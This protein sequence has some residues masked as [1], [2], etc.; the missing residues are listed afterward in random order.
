MLSLHSLETDRETYPREA[1]SGF[2]KFLLATDPNNVGTGC[3]LRYSDGSSTVDVTFVDDNGDDDE[4]GSDGDDGGEIVSERRPRSR[5]QNRP[6]PRSP[7]S[8]L[9]R[10][11]SSSSQVDTQ[12]EEDI[13]NLLSEMKGMSRGVDELLSKMSTSAAGRHRKVSHRRRMS[14]SLPDLS[15]LKKAQN[16]ASKRSAGSGLGVH[17][18]RDSMRSPARSFSRRGSYS[19]ARSGA[20]SPAGSSGSKGGGERGRSSSG[21]LKRASAASFKHRRTAGSMSRSTRKQPSDDLTNSL[22]GCSTLAGAVSVHGK[23]AKENQDSYL[24][25]EGYPSPNAVVFAIFDGHGPQGKKVSQFCA[26][27]FIATLQKF[28]FHEKRK[29]GNAEASHTSMGTGTNRKKTARC[30]TVSSAFHSLHDQLHACAFDTVQSGC[31]AVACVAIPA[32]QTLVVMHCGDSSALLGSVRPSSALQH[33]SENVQG[34]FH[35][36][37]DGF[38]TQPNHALDLAQSMVQVNAAHVVGDVVCSDAVASG[39]CGGGLTRSR[40]RRSSSSRTAQEQHAGAADKGHTRT[41][42]HGPSPSPPLVQ[43]KPTWRLKFLTREHKPSNPKER[44]RIEAA[45]G[46]VHCM[47]GS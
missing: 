28:G 46:I 9:S 1:E 35:K 14:Q 43:T 33:S 6:S 22:F 24:V 2:E 42:S 23:K 45:G 32:E 41:A 30:Q 29:A 47:D 16:S 7:A 17:N 15:V 5:G 20:R 4:E 26:D 39:D 44:L 31:T 13:G 38:V 12:M 25:H 37:G 34:E 40:P 21:G 36:K 19:C 18:S 3:R 10:P 11:R 27:N 8:R